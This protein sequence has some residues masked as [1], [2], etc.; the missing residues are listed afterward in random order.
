MKKLINILRQLVI[1]LDWRSRYPSAYLFGY[2]VSRVT[3]DGKTEYNQWETLSNY[4]HNNK[5]L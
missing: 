3:K 4:I 2:W 5:T 1:C